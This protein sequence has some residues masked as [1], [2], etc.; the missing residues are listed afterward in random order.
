[1]INLG[2]L[3]TPLQPQNSRRKEISYIVLY[4]FRLNA[5]VS[6]YTIAEVSAGA[7]LERAVRF[8]L[9]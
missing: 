3:E 1:M 5:S 7:R 2:L 4:K 8:P 9:P 6:A